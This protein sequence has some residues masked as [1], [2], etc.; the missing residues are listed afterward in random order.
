[1]NAALPR[2]FAISRDTRAF[3]WS[4]YSVRSTQ[5]ALD[6]CNKRSA[7]PC[8]LYAVDDRVVYVSQ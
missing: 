8:E 6:A 7:S 1:M 4:A 2:A 5:A 3:A